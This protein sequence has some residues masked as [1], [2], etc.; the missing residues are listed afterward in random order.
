MK[1]YWKYQIVRVDV[2]NV[3]RV[4]FFVKTYYQ[5]RRF[6]EICSEIGNTV[7]FAGGFSDR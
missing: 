4:D 7:T 5:F 6:Y 2:L 3:M 1:T